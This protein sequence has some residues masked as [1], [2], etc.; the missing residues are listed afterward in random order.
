MRSKVGLLDLL[1]D[2]A[3][4]INAII[5]ARLSVIEQIGTGLGWLICY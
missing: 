2:I 5:D 4:L 3:C 1:S